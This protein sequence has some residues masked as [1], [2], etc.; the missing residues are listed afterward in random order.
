MEWHN[1]WHGIVQDYTG[2]SL[3][4][5]SD[6]FPALQG[7]AKKGSPVLGNYVAGL[8]ES[9]LIYS[10]TWYSPNLHPLGRPQPW[11]APTWSWASVATR[12]N[13][14]RLDGTYPQTFA[15]IISV[16]TKA[17]GDDQTGEIID[18]W[19]VIKGMC[20]K[21]SFETHDHHG[22][23][24]YPTIG[25]QQRKYPKSSYYYKHRIRFVLDYD[26]DIPGP[27][28]IP[29]GT[30]VLL[31]KVDETCDE[32]DRR[33]RSRGW[34][35]LREVNPKKKVYERIGVIKISLDDLDTVVL[36]KRY[37]DSAK[38]MEVMIV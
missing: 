27:Y 13:F 19:L 11:R 15:T 25:F 6:I 34:L 3:T 14:F 38:E 30:E 17:V 29:S 4:Y 12:V 1:E 20:L 26:T 2:K 16:G 24:T 21:A 23:K 22:F 31:M 28:H 10:L 5:S 32:E 9:T 18:A 35:V 37:E 36:E 7:L 33:S 8:W